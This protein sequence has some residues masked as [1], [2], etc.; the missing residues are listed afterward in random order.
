MYFYSVYENK[1]GLRLTY[2]I[3]AYIYICNDDRFTIYHTALWYALRL[4]LRFSSTACLV[5]LLSM[6]LSLKY[7]TESES[8]QEDSIDGLVAALLIGQ[9]MSK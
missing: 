3:P 4:S 1:Y 6:M 8:E 5:M 9:N 7:R 2:N